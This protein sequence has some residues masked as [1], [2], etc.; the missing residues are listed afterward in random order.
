MILQVQWVPTGLPGHSQAKAPIAVSIKVRGILGTQFEMNKPLGDGGWI[1]AVAIEPA[2]GVI[3]L[4]NRFIIL[5][6][7]GVIRRGGD[8]ADP[9]FNN[10]HLDI[11]WPKR[12]RTKR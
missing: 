1:R 11:S 2:V 3:D 5:P 12:G 7:G 4:C 6:S 9:D 10:F 8:L